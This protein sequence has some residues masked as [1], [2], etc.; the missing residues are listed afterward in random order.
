[1]KN[2]YSLVFAIIVVLSNY[3][4]QF[5]LN[6]WFTY[7]AILFPIGF[8]L[9]DILSEKKEKEYTKEVIRNGIL[10]S[11]IPTVLV[12]DYRIALASLFAYYVSQNI[13]IVIFTTL[14]N[15][16]IKLWWLR[17]NLSTFISQSVDSFLF[18]FVAFYG[19]MTTSQLIM[20]SLG[21]L[22]LKFIMAIL[23]TPLFYYFGIRK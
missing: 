5:T 9:T 17:N 10:I 8:L 20:L 15:R 21:A 2:I 11:I 22:G 18:F 4:V 6:D 13:D 7:G 1:M 14:K 16:F 23:D 12:T 3:L 19:V